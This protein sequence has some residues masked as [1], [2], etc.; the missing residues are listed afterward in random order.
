MRNSRGG[1]FYRSEPSRSDRGQHPDLTPDGNLRPEA[2]IYPD[3]AERDFNA[4]FNNDPSWAADFMEKVGRRQAREPAYVQHQVEGQTYGEGRGAY[5]GFA[6]YQRTL[7]ELRSEED[8][9]RYGQGTVVVRDHEI[10]AM[11][12]SRFDELFDERGQPK[13]GVVVEHGSRSVRLDDG[14]DPFSRNELRGNR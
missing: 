1:G 10:E 14:I 13:P 7:A 6:E 8:A 11:P 4:R 3:P 12:L 5:A 9:Y 2:Y